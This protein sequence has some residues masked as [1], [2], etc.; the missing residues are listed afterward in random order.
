MGQSWV[1]KTDSWVFLDL[2]WVF[3]TEL[4][5]LFEPCWVFPGRSWVFLGHSWPSFSDWLLRFSGP[6][7]M[8]RLTFGTRVDTL[9]PAYDVEGSN[10]AFCS[11]HEQNDETIFWVNPELFWLKPEFCGSILSFCG[12]ILSLCGLVLNILECILSF[13][14]QSWV[15]KSDA[16]VFWVMLKFLRVNPERLTFDTVVDMLPSAYDVD[17]STPAFCSIHEQ[18]DDSFFWFNPAFF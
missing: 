13:S 11:I 18:N 3:L 14:G 12:S 8:E 6:S 15:F 16:V 1:F 10:P 2:S 7:F 5:V 9:S 4:R 17:G